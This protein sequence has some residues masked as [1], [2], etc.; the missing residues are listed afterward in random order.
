MGSLEGLRLSPNAWTAVETKGL[1]LQRHDL[2]QVGMPS[3][4]EV[5]KENGS[6]VL[7]KDYA[8]ES[9]NLGI[10]V[11]GLLRGPVEAAG[12]SIRLFSLSEVILVLER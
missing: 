10:T 1:R 6:H 7:T 4:Q 5:G 12:G 2:G 9:T 3:S 8:K 11:R